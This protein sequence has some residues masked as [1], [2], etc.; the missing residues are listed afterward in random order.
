MPVSPVY[1]LTV[2]DE[3][4]VSIL[5]VVSTDP[6]HA[7][8]YLK[9]PT[10]FPEQEVDFAK[11]TAS[12]GQVDV[13]VVDVPTDPTDQ[14]T[15]W[16]TAQLAAAGRSNLNGHRAV[17]TEDSDGAGPSVVSDGVVRGTRLL[18]TFA[19]YGIE[20]RDI[21]ERERKTKAFTNTTTPTV[22]PRG[23]LNGY[24]RTTTIPWFTGLSLTF[25]YPIA[26]TVPLIAVYDQLSVTRGEFRFQADQPNYQSRQNLVDVIREA[27]DSVAPLA[28]QPQVM[29]HNRFKVL[30]RDNAAG[31]AFTELEQLAFLHPDLPEGGGLP[32]YLERID[33]F[34]IPLVFG[35]RVN[36]E[37]TA[38]TLPS[39]AQLCDVI[40]QYDGPPTEDW[41]HHIQDV[42]AGELLRDLYRGDHSEED[43]RI[44]YDEAAL[45]ALATRVRGRLDEPIKDVRAWAEKNIYPIVHAAPTLNVAGDISPITYL[46]PDANETLADLNDTNC[47]PA[48]GGWSHGSEDAINLVRVTYKRE[49]RFN[50]DRRTAMPRGT[51]LSDLVLERDITIEHRVQDSIDLLGEQ[52]LEVDSVLLTTLGGGEGGPLDGDTTLETGYQ[53]AQRIQRMALDRFALGGQFFSLLVDR[54][55]A[56]VEPLKVGAWVTVSVSWMP[57]Y[58]SGERGLS[59]L[60]QVTSRRNQDATWAHLTLVDAGTANAPLLPPTLGGLTS[61][62]A[63]V[64]SVPI[65]TVPVDAE[66]RV[67]Y[68]VNSTEP[69]VDSELWEF[70]ARAGVSTVVTPPNP[71]GSTVWVRARSEAVGVRP[72]AY[73]AADSITVAGTPRI[74]DAFVELDVNGLP[75]V[76]W[77]GNEACL[78]VRIHYERHSYLTSPTFGDSVDVDVDDDDRIMTGLNTIH[79]SIFSV[80]LEP[81]TGWTGSAVSGSAG[82]RWRGRA[83]GGLDLGAIA[84]EDVSQAEAAGTGTYT[85]K[86]LDPDGVATDLYYRTKSGSADWTAWTLK[87]AT[88]ADDT[89][90]AE[91]VTLIEGHQSFIE[92]QLWYVVAGFT[93]KIPVASGGFDLGPVPNISLE[94]TI[95]EVGVMSANIQGDVDTASIKILASSSSQ[96]T[97]ANTRL[98]AAKDGR[99]FSTLDIG[100]LLTLDVGDTGYVTVF[101]YS[102]INGAGIESTESVKVRRVRPGLFTPNIFVKEVR[103]AGTSVITIDVEDTFLKVTAI[104][105][106]KRDGAEGGDTL[107]ASWQTAWTSE[108]GTIASDV[109]LQRVIN[110]P[111]AAGLEGEV[112][113]RVQFTDAQGDTETVGDSFKVV[114]LEALEDNAVMVS[115][116]DLVSG[117]ATLAYV[118]NTARASCES[119]TAGTQALLEGTFTLP[120]GVTATAVELIAYRD[121]THDAVTVTL[122]KVAKTAASSSTIVSFSHSTTGWQ[123]LSQ[124]ISELIDED[125]VYFFF[126]QITPH[127]SGAS[128]DARFRGFKMIYDRPAYSF[129]Y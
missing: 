108:V 113:W 70:L 76:Y 25:T 67:D 10:S 88:P 8:P 103:S 89:N 3:D 41:R 79:N 128:A 106:K 2:Y 53:V 69:A 114:N 82:P 27:F 86:V 78:G 125:T 46:L 120:P 80:E 65:A 71:Q 126:V 112:Q 63:G 104:E 26:P 40:V 22:L 68:A 94:L 50:P 15:G 21:R 66:C 95:D 34:G 62:A 109:T 118:L 111:V 12:I 56:L 98:E 61:N 19:T 43:P 39:D 74:V 36:N 44:R 49:Y 91:T 23:V 102:E 57:D 54:S 35:L 101:G 107:D 124:A 105:Y 90:Y 32:V 116:A 115:F 20:I 14:G 29:I 96:P 42:T 75:R 59:R 38:D 24:G 48:G 58:A 13:E 129:T 7:R 52:P 81:W 47:R 100:T 9:A 122:L 99:M 30:W 92:F 83:T 28:G 119:L 77:V 64:V 18:D 51:P 87:T 11:G 85:V 93:F 5:F 127:S 45:L 72:S 84:L 6:A 33:D 4:D 110:V 1:E 121:G 73:I 17:L 123:A 55:A 37:V 16:F 117:T 60:A 97:D 31:G